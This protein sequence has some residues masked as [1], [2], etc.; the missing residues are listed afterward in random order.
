MD[1]ASEPLPGN[2]AS[3]CRHW[4]TSSSSLPLLHAVRM[5]SFSMPANLTG[6]SRVFEDA[7]LGPLLGSGSYG[8]GGAGG[9]RGMQ[10]GSQRSKLMP[11][12]LPAALPS[13]SCRP[14]VLGALAGRRVRGQ[15]ESAQPGASARETACPSTAA[16]LLVT[17]DDGS[18]LPLTQ[19][20]DVYCEPLDDNT[21]LNVSTEKRSALLEVRWRGAEA[22]AAMALAPA[23]LPP[24]SADAC[25]RSLL[26]QALLGWQYTKHP[27]LVQTFDMGLR[28]LEPTHGADGAPLAPGTL[29]RHSLFLVMSLFN[30]GSLRA[31]S[32]A[33]AALLF[34]SVLPAV[35][36]CRRCKAKLPRPL[37]SQARRCCGAASA[38]RR[39]RAPAP[40]SPTCCPSCRRRRRLRAA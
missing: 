31:W 17:P 12:L 22:P 3:R 6:K 23:R 1:A 40:A 35:S 14:R 38:A 34:G 8:E 37:L 15:G 13:F 36:C 25:T 26:P 33:A 2:T 27:H 28:P 21:V 18:L 32:A 11:A 20:M 30:R 5:P 29:V 19:V 39:L 7:K 4:R 16:A 9:W 24:R 10:G